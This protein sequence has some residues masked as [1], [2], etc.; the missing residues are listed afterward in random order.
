MNI[1]TKCTLLYYIEQYPL[2]AN[3]LQTWYDELLRAK[4]HSFNELKVMYGNASIIANNRVIFNIRGN[5]FRLIVHINFDAQTLYII[6]FGS[7]SAYDKIDAA[8]IKYVKRLN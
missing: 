8:N 5:H 3:S 7:H 2:A 6:W 1:L 4:F